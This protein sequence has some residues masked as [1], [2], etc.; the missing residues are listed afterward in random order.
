MGIQLHSNSKSNR[1]EHTPVAPYKT[2]DFHAMAGGNMKKGSPMFKKPG[3]MT[4]V[5]SLNIAPLMQEFRTEKRANLKGKT[6][7]EISHK[8]RNELIE[9]FG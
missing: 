5:S 4:R 3:H 9:D 8:N 2:P 6:Y 7:H 1:K